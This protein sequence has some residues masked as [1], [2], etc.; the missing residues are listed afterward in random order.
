VQ[1][2]LV[3]EDQI[4]VGVSEVV[5][6]L[7]SGLQVGSSLCGQDET[8]VVIRRGRGTALSTAP[9]QD[10]REDLRIAPRLRDEAPDRFTPR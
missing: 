10:D 5:E 8:H 4:D 9:E 1:W 6:P 7:V 3:E 2:E